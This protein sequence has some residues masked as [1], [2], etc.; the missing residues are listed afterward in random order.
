MGAEIFSVAFLCFT[1]T[2]I[3]LSAGYLLLKLQG[4]EE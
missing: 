3:G 1:L 2:L 4:S